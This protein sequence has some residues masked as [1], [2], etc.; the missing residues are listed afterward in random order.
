M[1]LSLLTYGPRLNRRGQSL[2]LVAVMLIGLLAIAALAIDLGHL[3]SVRSRLQGMAD[4]SALAAAQELPAEVNVKAVA[5]AYATQNDPVNGTVI[6]PDEVVIGNW[7]GL[8][9]FTPGGAPINAVRVVARRAVVRNN[10]AVL[11]FARVFGLQRSDVAAWAT[12][13][14]GGSVGLLLP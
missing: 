2:V 11:F 12:A 9:N 7:D 8:G 4:A 14:S 13:T 10:A 5:Q 3:L 1:A 6:S